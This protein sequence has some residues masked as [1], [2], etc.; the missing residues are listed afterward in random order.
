VSLRGALARE[1]LRL[2][3]QPLVNIATEQII[4]FEA[5]LRW[6]HPDRGVVGPAEFIPVAEETGLIIPIGEWVLRR[7]CQDAATW[8]ADVRIAV[9]LSPVQ[10]RSQNLVQAVFSAL[11][12]SHLAPTRLDLEITET[13]L[14]N[15]SE[16]TLAILHQL[17]NLG[18]GISMDDF[19]TGYSSLSYLQK[20]PFSKIKID[21][22]FIRGLGEGAEALAIIRA[23]TGMTRSKATMPAARVRWRMPLP[24]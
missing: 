22:S 23:V 12:A 15:D 20:F 13:V 1:E 21:Q 5:L 2:E 18:V 8:P 19:G 4:G 10:F 6:D 7:A 14:L 16:T 24:C 3:Y 11:A 9:N 17:K